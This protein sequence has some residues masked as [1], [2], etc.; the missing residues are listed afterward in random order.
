MDRIETYVGQSILEW[1]FSKPDQ[2][3]M[4]ALGKVISAMFG[5]TTVANGMACTQQS[6]P[7]MFVNIAPG[8]IYQ[9]A[10]LEA[11]VCGTLPADT[12]HTIM[13]QG[14][15][16]DSVTVPNANTGVT[17]FTA[18][19]TSGQS[20]NYLIEAT[21]ADSDVSLDPTTGSSPVVL[22]FYNSSNPTSPYQ[23][24]N[25][26]GAT[27][28]TFRKGIVSLK[29]KA[30]TAAT[31]GAQVTPSV[32]SGYAGLFVI[33]VAYGQ[34]T[35]VAANISTYTGAP[36]LPTS[37]LASIQSGNLQYGADVST[38]ANVIQ[39]SFA[40]PPAT[41]VDNQ[42]FWVKIKNANT[43]AVT[44]TPNVGVI[45]AAPVVG[46]AHVALQGGECVANGRALLVWRAD[47]S[48]YV[49]E[50]CSGGAQQTAT[51]TANQHAATLG[52]VQSGLSSYAIDAG[53]AN[54]YV[55]T[56]SPAITA[57]TDGVKIRF[58]ALTANTG[59]ATLNVNGL[60]A[61]AVVGGAHSAL[62]GGEIIAGGYCE[63]E[64]N[65]A[66]SKFVLLECTGAPLQVAAATASQHAAQLGQVA[67][68][69][70]QARNLAMSVTTASASA[71][72]TADEIIVETALGGLRYCL[73]SF[74]KTINLATTGAGGMDTGTAPASG[75]VALY[76]IYN[77]ATATAAL[78]ATNAATK[79]GNV[80]GGT[81]MPSGYTASALI[82]VW[83]TNASS[84][85][86]AGFLVD[87]KFQ[88]ISSVSVL[89]TSATSTAATALSIAG[90]VPLNA[91]LASGGM[92]IS[93]TTSGT[94]Y[95]LNIG[96]STAALPA[97]VF[98]YSGINNA[99]TFGQFYEMPLLTQQTLAYST[100]NGSSALFTVSIFGYSI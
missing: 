84:Q 7:T 40:I 93:T 2:N 94:S 30:G 65:G 64:Y 32:D 12:A 4:V 99:Q 46:A 79:Q 70:G 66:L 63:A 20:I 48:S 41:L 61:V 97:G 44:F 58:R 11:T 57:Y 8:E 26:S 95:S 80:Y 45:S 71:T 98:F 21:Y 90:A 17:A 15:A 87:R 68:V 67:G 53:T 38:T 43:G 92:V 39:G 49:L 69:V 35:V 34:T 59:A 9:A 10:Q 27:S 25:G 5:S 19:S 55:V 28:N 6:V 88:Y 33:T 52:Q 100:T 81:N 72:L 74:S 60:G 62:V 3:K 24:P 73:A 77:P 78:L 13:K 36:I 91:R 22:P 54:T 83:P 47:I 85:F 1:N 50:S 89:S 51:A 18:P 75:Y 76:A 37:M 31:T 42:Q 14:I 23:G 56:L 86:T 82:G 29:V 16:L 96:P